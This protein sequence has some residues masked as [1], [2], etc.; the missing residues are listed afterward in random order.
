M[1]IMGNNKG[2]NWSKI[3][4]TS[5]LLSATQ[6]SIGS[7]ELSSRFSVKNFSKDQETLQN[8]ADALKQYLV[9][10][11]VWTLGTVLVMY[12]QE[13]KQGALCVLL[14]NLMYIAWIYISYQNAFRDA[15]LKY[16]L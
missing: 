9:V 7:I 5:L 11:F 16:K 15:A 10:A 1:D 13:G 6:A 14:F 2:T 8:A 12:S 3:V 4:G